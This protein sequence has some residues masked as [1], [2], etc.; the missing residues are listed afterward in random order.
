MQPSS[1]GYDF[2]VN[3]IAEG[4]IK[5]GADGQIKTLNPAA[6]R[7]IQA[8]E[9]YVKGKP[10]SEIPFFA[11]EYIN[12]LDL[13]TERCIYLL[14]EEGNVQ[15]VELKSERIPGTQPG[16]SDDYLILLQDVTANRKLD[17]HRRV[18]AMRDALTGIHNRRY[19]L[20]KLRFLLEPSARAGRQH[21]MIYLDLDQ[22]K[23]VNDACGHA[24]GD[25][26]LQ[27]ITGL[28][29]R[30]IRATDILCRLGGDEFGVL[31]IDCEPEPAAKVSKNIAKAI[32]DYAF[33]FNDDTYKLTSSIGLLD[34]GPQYT[35]P[36]E[37]IK[38]AEIA[39]DL[40]IEGGRNR[41]HRY[42]NS[43]VG[44]ELYKNNVD[45]V[46]RINEGLKSN[47]FVL[48]L[49]SIAPIN[50]REGLHG[51]VL[52]R[53][54]EEDGS[55]VMPGDFMP[56]VER[57]FI[58]S[59]VDTYILNKVFDLFETKQEHVAQVSMISINLSGQS[60]ND[61]SFRD[62]LYQKV[63][64]AQFP[65]N[66][67]C[68]EITETI[69]LNHLEEV[70]PFIERLRKLGVKFALDDFG[71]GASSFGYLR[72]LP[73][74][75]LK[76]DGQFI[77]NLD[78]D[79]V[80]RLTVDCLAKV[81]KLSGAETIA[82]WVETEAVYDVLKTLGVDYM[83]GYYHHKPEPMDA[84]LAARASTLVKKQAVS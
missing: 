25:Q 8:S 75:Y 57:F 50:G 69:A 80:S 56:C 15:Y 79:Q 83:Q 67:I 20:E 45:W 28:I 23:V 64:S 7:L 27:T 10:L 46:A 84:M 61:A 14:N 16:D 12:D 3:A 13:L 54:L 77:V 1:Q 22:F 65:V 55:L 72:K 24:Y 52:I 78:K 62:Y 11:K 59:K 73:V 37:V 49:Q 63:E 41:I 76:I 44:V 34:I 2:V 47:R 35:E 29:K 81:A 48:Y 74:D 4:V 71:N 82:E 19:F 30:C 51:E 9:G 70:V 17:E 58:A 43:D 21:A 6:E 38:D 36:S 18:D 40:A 26:L 66:K 42:E 68:F 53:L 5:V 33:E 60:V 32:R 39:C 31:L